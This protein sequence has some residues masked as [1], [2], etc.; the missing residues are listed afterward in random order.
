MSF[1]IELH[2]VPHLKVLINC[3]T[4]LV[5]KSMAVLLHYK[6]TYL[7]IPILL[8]TESR[9]YLFSFGSVGHVLPFWKPPINISSKTRLSLVLQHFKHL[10]GHAEKSYFT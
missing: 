6:K 8:P 4:Y 9:P 7:K 5:G 1:E 10:S 2:A 3:Q